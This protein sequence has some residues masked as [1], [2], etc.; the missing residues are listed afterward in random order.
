MI[1]AY[2]FQENI[3]TLLGKVSEAKKS[4]IKEG[5]L[6]P[7]TEEISKTV[8]I[9]VDRLEMLLF[10]TRTPVSIERPVWADQDTTFQVGYKFSL[11]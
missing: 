1:P 7:T 6:H 11:Q 5:N 2:Y 4:Y 9:T 8:G 10:S 3:Y